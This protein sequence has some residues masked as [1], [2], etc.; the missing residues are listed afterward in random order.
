MFKYL[1]RVLLAVILCVALLTGYSF[2]GQDD[3]FGSA[4][5]IESQHFTIYYA[6]GLDLDALARQLDIRPLDKLI[7]G[8]SYKNDLGGMIDTLFSQVGDIL[9][10]Q[11]YD[12]H[13]TIKI[14]RDVKQ[15]DGIYKNLFNT[16]PQSHSFYVN[17]LNTDY[18]SAE[19]FSREVLGHEIAHFITS[20]YFVV[21]PSPK[22][23]EVL[24]CFAEY[25]LRK[26]YSK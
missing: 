17:D 24:A 2:A 16:E 15:I 8:S 11:L 21:L 26:S 23:Q 7:S 13:G 18:V 25:Q 9:D 20:R 3:G 19:Y 22:I 14:C 5:K 1:K 12:F 4:Q 10:M 6:P